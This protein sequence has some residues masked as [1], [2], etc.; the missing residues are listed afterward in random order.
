MFQIPINKKRKL[1]FRKIS[2]DLKV[3][4]RG[5]KPGDGLKEKSKQ[6]SRKWLFLSV[7][8]FGLIII[9]SFNYY[10]LSSQKKFSDGSLDY[11]FEKAVVY[12]IVNH[13]QLYPQVA[14]F[15]QVLRD[16]NLINQ[17]VINRFNQYLSQTR[18][19][20]TD[21]IKTLF[22][23]KSALMI[24]PANSDT[25]FP[26]LI[27]LERKENLAKISQILDIIESEM[28]KDFSISTYNYRQ[29]KVTMFSS[30]SV[31]Y[32]QFLYT[33]IEKY[34]IVSNSK[35]SLEKAIDIIINSD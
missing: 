16:N 17:E 23:D 11:F 29:T 24:L 25:S 7:I 8:L 31:T 9:L 33:Q 12:T 32:T 28:N 10:T 26:F 3:N 14:L 5:N 1:S 21:N 19:N 6:P 20:F 13:I 2:E 22:K 15:N 27:V 34:L 35:E 4:L 18:L 30:L